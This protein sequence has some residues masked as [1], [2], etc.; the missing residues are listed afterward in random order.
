MNVSPVFFFVLLSKVC[1]GVA[2]TLTSPLHSLPYIIVN[3]STHI[4]THL[5]Y[6]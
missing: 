6:V 3:L 5:S 2:Y 1:N 4:C